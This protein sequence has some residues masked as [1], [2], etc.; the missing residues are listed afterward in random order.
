M[1]Y[2]KYCSIGCGIIGSGSIESAQMFLWAS[3]MDPIDSLLT[4]SFDFR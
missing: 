1:D 2:K 3:T 4:C